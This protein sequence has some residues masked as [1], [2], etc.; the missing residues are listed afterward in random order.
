[1]KMIKITALVMALLILLVGCEPSNNAA[2]SEDVDSSEEATS[3]E[4]S[5]ESESSA[6]E[7]GSEL[8]ADG[9]S[10]VDSEQSCD[11]SE[12]IKESTDSFEGS[13]EPDESKGDGSSESAKDNSKPD[14]S[15]APANESKPDESRT[16]SSEPDESEPD[17][18][19]APANESKADSSEEVV[20]G[21]THTWTEVMCFEPDCRSIGK[22]KLKCSCGEIKWEDYGELQTCKF[23]YWKAETGATHVSEGIQ[24]YRC[25]KC[26]KEEKRTVPK[27]RELN[28][29]EVDKICDLILELLN[30]ERAK[31]GAPALNTAPIAH[32]MAMVRAE[33]LSIR[34]D[35]SHRRPDGRD[36]STIYEDYK[37]NPDTAPNPDGSNWINDYHPLKGSENIYG[38]RGYGDT[39]W[40]GET[41][42][43]GYAYETIESFR[44]SAGHWKDLTNP[45]YTGVGI[46]VYF[47]Y[48]EGGF[49]CAIMTMDKTY[50]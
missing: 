40:D 45:E 1:M 42:P 7:N 2:L 50:G 37:Y 6:A 16:D 26:G 13:T 47:D 30:E 22:R 9:E 23:E 27:I 46:G 41:F 4:V 34:F 21:H 36:S 14:E 25:T 44:G 20:V 39:M 18:S 11:S 24:I 43:D 17:E 8:S 5:E 10:T 12:E 3:I 49:F 29:A 32:E 19:K 48:A 35:S 15:K 28:K 33:E 31:V 38:G